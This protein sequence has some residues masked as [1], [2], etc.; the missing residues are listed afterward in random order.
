MANSI[1][2]ELYGMMRKPPS[3]KVWARF[4]KYLNPSDWTGC[5]EW[6]GCRLQGKGYGRFRTPTTTERTHQLIMY[7]LTG[8]RSTDER[9]IDHVRCDNPPCSNPVHLCYTTRRINILR[10]NGITA[11]YSRKTHCIRGHALTGANISQAVLKRTGSR[12]CKSCHREYMRN[13]RQSH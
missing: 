12:H 8:V 2:S 7:W 9:P 13:Y 11:I 4:C 5:W 3:A 1:L 6:Q 10:S